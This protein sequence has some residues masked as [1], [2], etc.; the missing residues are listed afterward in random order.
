MTKPQSMI[1]VCTIINGSVGLAGQ[2]NDGTKNVRAS[3]EGTDAI[4][5]I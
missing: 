4:S 2:A 5:Q 1:H 3:I